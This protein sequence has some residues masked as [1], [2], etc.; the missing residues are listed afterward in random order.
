MTEIIVEEEPIAK[1]TTSRITKESISDG[2]I[3][4]I[5]KLEK[6]VK[7]AKTL[8]LFVIHRDMSL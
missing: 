3:D 7:L 1:D 4:D 6:S 2:A 5:D 8:D